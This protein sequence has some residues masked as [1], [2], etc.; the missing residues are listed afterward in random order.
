MFYEKNKT[1]QK[2]RPEKREKN[3]LAEVE[4]RTFDK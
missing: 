4:S 1:K 3:P 2:K